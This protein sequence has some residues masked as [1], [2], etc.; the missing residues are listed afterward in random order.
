MQSKMNFERK[1]LIPYI[2]LN[3]DSEMQSFTLIDSVLTRISTANL[4][5]NYI[6]LKDENSVT[7]DH[8]I[9]VRDIKVKSMIDV[10]ALLSF[11]RLRIGETAWLNE[12]MLKFEVVPIRKLR[13]DLVLFEINADMKAM[14]LQGVTRIALVNSIGQGIFIDLTSQSAI[15]NALYA[16]EIPVISTYH[17]LNWK[18]SISV[19]FDT[20]A[21][22]SI[23]PFSPLLTY[24]MFSQRVFKFKQEVRRQDSINI[25]TLKYL[26]KVGALLCDSELNDTQIMNYFECDPG[27]QFVDI[28]VDNIFK[29]QVIKVTRTDG[30]I[31]TEVKRLLNVNE[32][33]RMSVDSLLANLNQ[34]YPKISK[35]ML[36]VLIEDCTTLAV[37]NDFVTFWI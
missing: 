29:Q 12:K 33:N 18:K 25:E 23:I 22:Y 14:N 28:I 3:V 36:I 37:Y 4:D 19:A 16:I 21:F 10:M 8:S 2:T 26:V 11:E 5:Y 34:A 30:P 31:I 9:I 35:E 27:S 6:R 1:V 32:G 17:Y 13:S 15:N 24:P 20:S 7:K